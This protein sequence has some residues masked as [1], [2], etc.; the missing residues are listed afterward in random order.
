[1]GG[2]GFTLGGTR[3]TEEATNMQTL[4]LQEAIRVLGNRGIDHGHYKSNFNHTAVL[5]TAYLG[6]VINA[7]DVPL[8]MALHKISRIKVGNKNQL[9]HYTDICGYVALAGAVNIDEKNSGQSQKNNV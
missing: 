3:M 7:E 1:M 2:R 8:M 9:D 5:W 6:V 4:I